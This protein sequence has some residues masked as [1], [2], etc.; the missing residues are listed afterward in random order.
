MSSS[1]AKTAKQTSVLAE[2]LE[3]DDAAAADAFE[4]ASKK[5]RVSVSEKE[6]ELVL[7]LGLLGPLG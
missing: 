4:A 6:N 2:S 5:L 1:S 3:D 7:K